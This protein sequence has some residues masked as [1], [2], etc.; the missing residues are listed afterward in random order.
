MEYCV[1]VLGPNQCDIFTKTGKFA[2]K[3]PNEIIEKAAN[4]K[5]EL[6]KLLSEPVPY[7]SDSVKQ[8]VSKR[9]QALATFMESLLIGVKRQEL[10]L[11]LLTECEPVA[12]EHGS[13]MLG[14]ISP[15]HHSN[16]DD[17]KSSSKT[18]PTYNQLNYYENLNRFFTSVQPTFV[19]NEFK[20][21]SYQID[22]V[23]TNEKDRML[24]PIQQCGEESGGSFNSS[25]DSPQF[26]STNT[27]NTSNNG[28]T[29]QQHLM[30]TEA[31][32]SRHTDAMELQMVKNHKK[33]RTRSSHMTDKKKAPDKGPSARNQPVKRSWPNEIG[34]ELFKNSKSNNQNEHRYTTNKGEKA[35][36]DESVAQP[37]TEKLYNETRP[38]VSTQHGQGNK[39]QA[40]HLWPPFSVNST[41]VQNNIPT[42]SIPNSIN[43]FLLSNHL[44][45][46]R[47]YIPPNN[48]LTMD[49]VILF[50]FFINIIQLALILTFDVVFFRKF[51]I[52]HQK[53][54]IFN[55][56]W[57]QPV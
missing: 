22:H 37:D 9:C 24:S 39:V 56:I 21:L 6:L 26:E 25:S 3:F 52:H 31:I 30:L 4:L 55:Q 40:V 34:N 43:Q 51:V 54:Q 41:T 5:K 10:K 12:S 53:K 17:S 27:S 20:S 19:P 36:V 29:N 48:I 23:P 38:S 1:F 7:P 8:Q 15:H 47:Y 28:T 35:Q 13:V 45:T 11:D 33:Y 18:P 57:Y 16:H 14:E 49:Q 44:S 50:S 2:C 32:V 46:P 42:N